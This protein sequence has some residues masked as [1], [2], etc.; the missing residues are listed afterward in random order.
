MVCENF[1]LL[2]SKEINDQRRAGTT[3]K[4]PVDKQSSSMP[5]PFSPEGSPVT[6]SDNELPF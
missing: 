6:I 4:V 5:D 1:Q 3:G 2:E